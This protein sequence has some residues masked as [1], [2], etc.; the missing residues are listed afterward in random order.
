MTNDSSC[1]Q[2]DR[3][4]AALAGS[5]ASDEQQQIERHLAQCESCR[6]S[7]EALAGAADPPVPPT[8]IEGSSGARQIPESL[9]QAIAQLREN[10]SRHDAPRQVGP[11]R[12]RDLLGA[13]GMGE[14]YRAEQLHPIRRTVAIK[15]IKLGMDTREVIARFESERQALALMNHPNVARV[16]D[17]GA[18]V[19]G[20]PYFVMEYVAGEPITRFCDRQKL[21][22]RQ[23]LELFT[24]ACEA[25]QHAHQKAIIHRD[26]KPSNILVTMQDDKPLVKVIDFGVA[27]ATAQKLTERTLFTQAGKMIGT[28]EYMSPEQAEMS[29]VDVDTRT[30]I[31][32]LGVLLYELLTGHLPFDPKT[33]RE[34]AYVEIQRIVRE[35]DP[36]RP[37]TRLSSLSLEQRRTVADTR[38][39]GFEELAHELRRELEWIPLRA[40]RKD[41]SERYRTASEL[42]DDV[43]N[44]LSGKALVA[45]PESKLYRTRKFLRRH[46]GPVAA[47]AAVA[48]SLLLGVVMT[49]FALI[50]QIRARA[51]ADRQQ[52]QAE[53]HR[54]EAERQKGL[55]ESR[56]A[57]SEEV[58]KFLSNML[59]SADPAKLL[60]DKVTV[61]QAITAAD[62]EL[63]QGRLKDQP[64]VEAAVRNTIGT[65][66][67]ALGRYDQAAPNLQRALDLRRKSLLAGHPDIVVSLSALAELLSD[68][69]KLD[70]AGPLYREALAIVRH[71]APAGHPYISTT[72]NNL[73][74]LERDQGRLEQAEALFREA[75]AIARSASPP[76]YTQVATGLNNLSAVLDS[77][78]KFKE[79]E[80]LVRE[81]LEL[82][83]RV[84]PAGHPEI[85][86]SSSNLAALLQEQGKFTEAEAVAREALQIRRQTLPA[87]HPDVA[88]SL[89]CL[90]LVLSNL[91]N[92]TEAEA[93]TREALEIRR[94]ALPAGH[95]DI[96]TS[97]NTLGMLLLAQGKL[98]DAEDVFREALEIRRKALP[99]AHRAIASSLSNLSTVL[100]QQR[101][102]IEAEP[103]LHQAI[104]IQRM[105]A[106]DPSI[107]TSLNNLAMILKTQGKFFEAEPLYREALT[108][109]RKALPSAHPDIA[110]S[111]NNLGMLLL[112]QG[113][114]TDAEP[115]LSEALDIRRETLPPG[116]ASIAESL[117]NLAVLRAK[118]D[119]LDEAESLNREAL[120]MF[121]S[122]LP[123]GHP[124]IAQ[125]RDNLTM[126][127]LTQGKLADAEPLLRE[128]LQARVQAF[129]RNAPPT[130]R[131]AGALA[132]LLS[133]MNREAEARTVRETYNPAT[134]SRPAT[135]SGNSDESVR[136]E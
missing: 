9:R 122:A 133:Q 10:P 19:N 4:R 1:P 81:A 132:D 41:R 86:Q 34:A 6:K 26:I 44:Y 78:G 57:E 126:F 130:T 83:R 13:G 43:R 33:L 18:D 59:A 134:T 79:A 113:K 28:P 96:A 117:N 65:T 120:A 48:I 31:Y 84:L 46:R 62:R 77:Q 63:N 75:L 110:Q 23:R 11:Y 129:G 108:V 123:A 14:V 54:K 109:R 88:V 55:A 107:A 82:R 35:Q 105:A 21:S 37:S 58:T 111:L 76:S 116:H 69:G 8:G 5:A 50:G 73:A 20:R 118:Q 90:A 106:E 66:L 68:Q 97:L 80:P 47:A 89:N 119:K 30:D 39:T 100:I 40:L 17:A 95:V 36:P 71:N 3:L 128:T 91:K 85:A 135:S 12:I 16:I 60:G 124:N 2:T 38:Q 127:F 114:L 24:Q 136:D 94:N 51:E 115:L 32:S 49:T 104:G 52:Q 125:S 101:R 112:A 121:R 29:G 131:T 103:L 25:V 99:A 7:L 102:L 56:E 15:L 92:P 67:R 87:G 98:A 27:K 93:L 53:R 70:E 22:I 45:A 72:L 61:L 74:A 42:A 64:L